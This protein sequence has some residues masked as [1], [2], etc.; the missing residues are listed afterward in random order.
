MDPSL[1]KE[2]DQIIVEI[3]PDLIAFRRETHRHPELGFQE[4]ATSERAKALL[5][6]HGLRPTYVLERTG[7]QCLIRGKKKRRFHSAAR[8]Y[9]LSSVTGRTRAALLL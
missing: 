2:I 7:L 8:R 4:Y 6:K 9:G 5:E 3:L 1:Q